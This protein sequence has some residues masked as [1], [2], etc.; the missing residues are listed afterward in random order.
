[1]SINMSR[2]VNMDKNQWITHK[3]TK[4]DM[5]MDT[6]M[7]MDTGTDVD[8]GKDKDTDTKNF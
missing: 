1:M 4:A 3:D 2:A 8:M 6:D 7:D 5:E